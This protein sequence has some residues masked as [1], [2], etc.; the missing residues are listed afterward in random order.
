MYLLIYSLLLEK[1]F[2]IVKMFGFTDKPIEHEHFGFIV[3]CSVLII[4]LGVLMIFCAIRLKKEQ[5]IIK[6]N[7]VWTKGNKL[8]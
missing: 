3:L 2:N 7:S 1:V 4:I 8:N 6:I 5:V